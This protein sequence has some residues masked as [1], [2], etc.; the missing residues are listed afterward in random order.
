MAVGLMVAPPAAAA[1]TVVAGSVDT[2]AR[3]ATSATCAEPGAVALHFDS[4]LSIVTMVAVTE[5]SGV[6]PGRTPFIAQW[7]LNSE[8]LGFQGSDI[9]C[10]GPG[11]FTLSSGGAF[12]FRFGGAV[13]PSFTMAGTL[14]RGPTF[15]G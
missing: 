10:V 11:S 13:G 2:A 8:C 14:V 15:G 1:H 7:H 5:C 3:S 12:S 6:Y 9:S 4:Q